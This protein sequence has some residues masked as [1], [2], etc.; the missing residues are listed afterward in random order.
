[1]SYSLTRTQGVVIDGFPATIH[2]VS[3]TCHY[4]VTPWC[5]HLL[6]EE[7]IAAVMADQK[8]KR[9][10]R[11]KRKEEDNKKRQDEQ[12]KREEQRKKLEAMA[13]ERQRNGH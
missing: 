9:A 10:E 1:M 5:D 11:R 8:R 4:S 7:E 2:H 12:Q 3:L 6:S 13:V